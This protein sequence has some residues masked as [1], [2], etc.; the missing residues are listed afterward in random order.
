MPPGSRASSSRSEP[1]TSI[2]TT[3]ST[4]TIPFYAT[5]TIPPPPPLPPPPPPPPPSQER[6]AALEETRLQVA[7]EGRADDIMIREA[8]REAATGS[9]VEAGEQLRAQVLSY[10]LYI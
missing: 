5:P 2:N 8:Q 3:I 1:T 6:D 4:T 9:V 7:A 10:L